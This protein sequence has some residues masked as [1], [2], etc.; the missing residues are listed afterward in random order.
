MVEAIVL[1]NEPNNLSHWNFH[2]DPN[3]S[4]FAEMVKAAAVAIRNIN[5]ELTIVL[6]GVS[7]CDPDFLRRMS[8][9]GV[10]EYVDGFLLWRGRSAGVWAGAYARLAKG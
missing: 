6:G 5:P 1:W 7:S 3:W 2:L 10:M 9:L 8:E 4:R